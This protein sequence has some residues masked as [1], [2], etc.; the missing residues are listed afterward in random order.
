MQK[1]TPGWEWWWVR[2]YMSGHG[3]GQDEVG[4]EVVLCR[5]G[6][7]ERLDDLIRSVDTGWWLNQWQGQGMVGSG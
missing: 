3:S 4:T 6:Y 5:G 7:G 2:K 1:G